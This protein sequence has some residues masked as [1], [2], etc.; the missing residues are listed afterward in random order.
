MKTFCDN[1]RQL[2]ADRGL[3]HREAAEM[4]GMPQTNFSRMLRGLHEPRLGTIQNLADALGVSCAD[5]LSEE[6]AGQ[7]AKF[8]K[9]AS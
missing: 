9:C 4:L 2:L 8:E 3:T 6:M 5:L 7:S 1:V